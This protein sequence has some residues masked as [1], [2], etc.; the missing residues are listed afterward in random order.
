MNTFTK[1]FLTGLIAACY[2]LLNS[3]CYGIDSDLL[4]LILV[5][6]LFP[7]E[8]F[9][10]VSLL[11][12]WK[13]WISVNW[14]KKIFTLTRIKIII[15]AIF[16]LFGLYSVIVDIYIDPFLK[17]YINFIMSTFFSFSIALGFADLKKKHTKRHILTSD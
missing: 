13:S 16:S 1:S 8:W 2:F 10:L 7:L 9:L 15:Y 3:I 4:S 14:F 17:L 11:I 5:V 12:I 6:L